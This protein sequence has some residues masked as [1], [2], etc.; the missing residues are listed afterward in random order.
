MVGSIADMDTYLL[1]EAAVFRTCV[2]L[3]TTLFGV[4]STDEGLAAGIE[5]CLTRSL[6]NRVKPD[7]LDAILPR[8]KLHWC[9]H[10]S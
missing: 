6:T 8:A 3:R 5:A 10:V 4:T 1:A 2:A 7:T 9:S